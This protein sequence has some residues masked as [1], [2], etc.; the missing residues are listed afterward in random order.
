MNL[1][2]S[3]TNVYNENIRKTDDKE[4]GI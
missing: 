1:Y 2:I 3:K 4:L